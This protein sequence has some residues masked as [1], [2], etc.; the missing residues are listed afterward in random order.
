MKFRIL[1]LCMALA[2]S[3]LLC[4]LAAGEVLA[5]QRP[6]LGK[7]WNLGNTLEVL[8]YDCTEPFMEFSDFVVAAPV[9]NGS[10]W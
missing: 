4:W 9:E 5:Q 10:T 2:R 8:G 3:A 7:G 1:R 6:Y